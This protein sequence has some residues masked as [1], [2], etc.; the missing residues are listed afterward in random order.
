MGKRALEKALYQLFIFL[1]LK[2]PF[3]NL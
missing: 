2:S 1:S 3:L